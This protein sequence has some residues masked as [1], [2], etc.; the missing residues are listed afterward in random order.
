[1]SGTVSDASL[2]TTPGTPQYEAVEW[3][4]GAD[5]LYICPSTNKCTVIQRYT[6]A[7][8]YYSTE[9]DSW[10]QCSESDQSCANSFL[11]P[12]DECDWAGITCNPAKC[13]TEITFGK[14][15]N[16]IITNI[17]K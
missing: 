1:M 17:G 4:I 2:L 5:A 8:F 12:I 9:G 16:S 13:V 7:L 6:M 15:S 3:L 14:Y 10:D 11:S